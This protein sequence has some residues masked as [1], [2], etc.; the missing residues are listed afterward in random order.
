MEGGKWDG[1]FARVA[2]VEWSGECSELRDWQLA[3][4]GPVNGGSDPRR[5]RGKEPIIV[6]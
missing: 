2:G 6:Q 5:V 1:F 4:N 3:G